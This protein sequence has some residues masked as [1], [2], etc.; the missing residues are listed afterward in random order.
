[1]ATARNIQAMAYAF[2]IYG[3]GLFNDAVSSSLY[4]KPGASKSRMVSE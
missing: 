3:V 4:C 1:M 2:N